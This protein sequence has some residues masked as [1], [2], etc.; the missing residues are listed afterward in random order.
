L[1]P[2]LAQIDEVKTEADLLTVSSRLSVSGVGVL[3]SNY[4]GQD[5]KNSDQMV[6]HFSQGGLG[7]PSREYYLKTDERTA[8]NR[9]A[10]IRHIASMLEL[11]GM[12]AA[13]AKTA[14]QQVFQ[15]EKQLA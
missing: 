12:N 10:Y 8:K 11:S 7:L 2:E 15:I 14:S 6:V 3:C 13:D 1:A 9:A 4:I 5:D